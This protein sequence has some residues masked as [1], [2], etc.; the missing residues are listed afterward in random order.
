MCIRDRSYSINANLQFTETLSANTLDIREYGVFI[1]SISADIEYIIT[2]N[3]FYI[4][5][6]E[7][8]KYVF[9]LVA[10]WLLLLVCGLIYFRRWDTIDR[11]I[12][13]YVP[14]SSNNNVLATTT[15][16]NE[17][18]ADTLLI[19]LR[20]RV[21]IAFTERNVLPESFFDEDH[22]EYHRRARWKD[23]VRLFLL[24]CIPCLPRVVKYRMSML[25]GGQWIPRLFQAVA[26][27]HPY[28]WF[29]SNRSLQK[30]RV[31][32]FISTLKSILVTI[33]I[34]TIFFDIF[35]PVD[36][37]CSS[38][39]NEMSSC[40]N[41][42]S[43]IRSGDPECIW[44]SSNGNCYT[45]PAPSSASFIIFVSIFTTLVLI[46]FDFIFYIVLNSIC[47][48]RPDLDRFGVDTFNILGTISGTPNQI[49]V[50]F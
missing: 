25:V 32:R 12:L 16:A 14:S 50:S 17:P 4:A 41:V 6:N 22:V 38:H 15:T 13:L 48:C 35:Y 7:N 37:V 11:N 46:P 43:R 31:I 18:L 47:A 23:R 19:Y 34:S 1:K 42:P 45:A 44:D 36:G 33:F 29:F 9:S 28:L 2:R 10:I 5:E 3:P 30:T 40:L 21:D 27:Y 26:R 24:C 8:A 49:D 39:T 20:K